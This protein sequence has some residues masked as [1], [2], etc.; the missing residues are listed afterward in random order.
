M[1][2]KSTEKV[3]FKTIMKTNRNKMGATFSKRIVLMTALIFCLV[4]GNPLKAQILIGPSY[5]NDF[6]SALG[7]MYSRSGA[8]IGA[9]YFVSSSIAV[10]FDMSYFGKTLIDTTFTNVGSWRTITEVFSVQ[11]YFLV[12]D[13][14]PY[15][16]VGAGHTSNVVESNLDTDYSNTFNKNSIAVIP[17]I[18]FLANISPKVKLTGAVRYNVIFGHD[19][20]LT[21]FVGLRVP[22]KAD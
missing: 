17:E 12:S 22:L 21:A 5:G 7:D 3:Y 6:S 14:R 8:Q 10:S 13:F 15:I 20:S 18:G 11:Y 1:K 19:H 4:T 16:G 2:N 9:S